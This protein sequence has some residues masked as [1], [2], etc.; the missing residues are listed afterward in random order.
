MTITNSGSDPFGGVLN[1][2]LLA[3]PHD[4]VTGATAVSSVAR[5]LTIP[6]GRSVL[7]SLNFRSESAIGPGTY[8]MI[9]DVTQ[10]NGTVTSTNPATAPGFTI[11]APIVTPLF[12][13]YINSA[14]EMYAPDT[15][16]SS[17]QH[18]TQLDLQMSIQ[19]NGT[20]SLGADTFT[21]F[22]S[23]KT[24]F[25]SSAIKET[26]LPLTLYI[27]ALQN[28]PLQIDFGIPDNGP[29]N[30][31]AINYYIFVQV[32]DTSGDVTMASYPTPISFAGPIGS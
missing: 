23:T 9:S 31:T 27:Y 30:G 14:G 2:A 21:L 16:D 20:N 15:S 4:A 24:T 11:Q 10:P 8:Q 22:A 32:T 19:N 5:K 13:D 28:Y 29:D 26:S 18:I 1:I 6:A 3:A 17:A 12:V 25:D 7:V